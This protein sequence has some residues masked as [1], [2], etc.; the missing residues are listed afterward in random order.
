MHTLETGFDKIL[1][2][3]VRIRVCGLCWEGDRLLLLNHQGLYGHPFW[4]P[5]GGGIDFGV[6]A[7]DQLVREFL[8]ETGLEVM[9]GEFLFACEFIQNPLHAVEL[10]FEVRIKGG[11]LKKGIDPEYPENKQVITDARYFS[12]DELWQIPEGH[13]HGLFRLAKTCAKIRAL[14]GYHKI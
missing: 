1:G 6:P 13:R 4:S 14:R 12:E 9:T 8:E 7:E 2:N 11:A 5:P 3:K 10:F